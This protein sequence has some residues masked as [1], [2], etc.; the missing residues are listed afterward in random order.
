MAQAEDARRRCRTVRAS[1]AEVLPLA[2][3]L[4]DEL[5]DVRR[6]GL[7]QRELVAVERE[8]HRDG[9]AVREQPLAVH[10][11]QVF[12]QAAECPGAVGPQAEHVAADLGSLLAQPMGLGKQVAVEQTQEVG[13]LVLVAVVRRGGEQQEMVALG[14]QLRRQFVPL[15]GDHLRFASGPAAAGSGGALVGLV[16]DDQVP[17][18]L[19]D[20]L[21]DVILL[22]VVEGG[23]DLVASLPG[24]RQLLLVD[25]REDDVERLAEPALHF[26]LPLDRQRRRAQDQDA[27]NRLA[28]LQFLVGKPA[29]IV[30]PAPGSSASSIRKHGCGS[31]F[32]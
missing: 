13:E 32:W 29:M 28:E 12:L 5:V 6:D 20:P 1:A 8:G 30:L 11:L 2:L 3:L 26:V 25:G 27:V 17:V 21:A 14:C 31:I 15:G 7:V 10:V 4:R 16:D 9:V 22:G 23:D 24:V 19:P 18:L